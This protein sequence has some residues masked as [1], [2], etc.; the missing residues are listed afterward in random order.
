MR[1]LPDRRDH[2]DTEDLG[3][4]GLEVIAVSPLSPSRGGL[5]LSGPL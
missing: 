4:V 2:V 3:V 1:P 5:A